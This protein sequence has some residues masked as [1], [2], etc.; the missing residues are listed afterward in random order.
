MIAMD[1]RA[2]LPLY[3]FGLLLL[4]LAWLS[5][6]DLYPDLYGASLRIITFRERGQRGPGAAFSMEHAYQS[7]TAAYGLYRIF[8]LL[9]GSWAIAWKEWIAFA[10]S[11]GMQ[12]TFYTGV[13]CSAGAGWFFGTMSARSKSPG[14]EALS[15]ASTATITLILFIAMGSAVGLGADLRKPLWWI[16]R[17]PLWKRLYAWTCGT[18]WRL[19]AVIYAGILTWAIAMRSPALGFF[20]I[21]IAVAV[22][23]HLRAVGLV[24]YSLFPST[25][26]QRGPLAFVRALLTYVLAA[27][28]IIVG[29]VYAVVWHA[30]PIAASIAILLALLESFLLVLFAAARISGRGFTFA[31]AEGM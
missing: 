10:R 18:S 30:F 20:G 23:I 31:Q 27:P 12:R 7:R 26:D 16:G 3:G 2:L 19:G 14:E 5:G 11:P 24:I 1:P 25:I 6:S 15:L 22:V 8:D 21:P 17:D 29:A 4:L 28:P 9:R 13:L